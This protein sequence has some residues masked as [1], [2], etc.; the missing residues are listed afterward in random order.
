VTTRLNDTDSDVT[1]T[2]ETGEGQNRITNVF[3]IRPGERFTFDLAE[4]NGVEIDQQ[5]TSLNTVVSE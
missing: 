5:L 3:V 4:D 1:V 2:F